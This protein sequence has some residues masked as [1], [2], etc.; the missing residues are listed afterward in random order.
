MKKRM[1]ITAL[2]LIAFSVFLQAQT[3]EQLSK[4]WEHIRTGE[5]KEAITL[6][7]EILQNEP[8]NSYIMRLLAM[9]YAR[10]NEAESSLVWIENSIRHGN[11]DYLEFLRDDDFETV[12]AHQRFKELMKLGKRLALEENR[13]K[14]VLEYSGYCI[15]Q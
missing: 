10:E 6:S 12:H 2:I 3:Q 14:A 11:T 13:E 1:P 7:Y 4:L 15:I 5:T 8:E 9:A